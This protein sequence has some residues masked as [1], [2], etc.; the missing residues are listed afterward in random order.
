M[1]R[2]KFIVALLAVMGLSVEVHGG[3]CDCA[4][5]S[6][7]QSQC[8]CSDDRG[9]L[10]HFDRV[11][12]DAHARAKKNFRLPF[13]LQLK[14]KS[15]NCDLCVAPS[16][17]CEIAASCGCEVT[18]SCGCEGHSDYTSGLDVGA[19]HHSGPLPGSTIGPDKRI[20]AP[21]P[22]TD[23]HVNPFEDEVPR[24]S[25]SKVR[26]RTI[27]YRA[28]PTPTQAPRVRQPRGETYGQQ[29]STQAN[30]S[31][32]G[33][34]RDEHLVHGGTSMPSGMQQ[35]HA[36]QPVTVDQVFQSAYRLKLS[37]S[38]ESQPGV[39]GSVASVGSPSS[40]R[41]VPTQPSPRQSESVDQSKHGRQI[42]GRQVVA[43]QVP[44]L[45]ESQYD[46]PGSEASSSKSVVRPVLYENPLR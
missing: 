13:T 25:N 16:C 19:H 31:N 35:R 28:Q 33:N 8:Q 46:D 32:P 40:L 45:A 14:K 18:A 43:V 4:K 29:Y 30:H 27:Q 22:S 23:L 38:C 10:D 42:A 20:P 34:M 5:P 2:S 9:L 39:A 36:A 15:D 37:D 17:G 7:C 41:P 1:K 6:S 21:V 44:E 3:D 24:S 26:G 12:G 11:A